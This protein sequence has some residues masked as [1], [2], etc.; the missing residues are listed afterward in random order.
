MCAL[1]ERRYLQRQLLRDI[2]AVSTVVAQRKA[3]W[4]VLGQFLSEAA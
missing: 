3:V 4:S 1:I 2:E